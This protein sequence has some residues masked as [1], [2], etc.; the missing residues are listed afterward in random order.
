MPNGLDFSQRKMVE[1]LLSHLSIAAIVT[2]QFL[3]QRSP[4][5]A[6]FSIIFTL[7]IVGGLILWDQDRWKKA[8]F[9]GPF[10]LHVAALELGALSGWVCS[11]VDRHSSIWWLA[12]FLQ[13]FQILLFFVLVELA[14]D[15]RVRKDSN[16][17]LRGVSCMSAH[18][19]TSTQPLIDLRANYVDFFL[20]AIFGASLISGAIHTIQKDLD[21]VPLEKRF[22]F[23]WVVAS[24][25]IIFSWKGMAGH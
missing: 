23:A 2:A 1:R 24:N 3:K 9:P 11:N 12:L 10:W 22:V 16:Y 13:S 20:V 18:M 6:A 15:K 25:V 19:L 4:E 14:T 17:N 8:G 21:P 7:S 5:T